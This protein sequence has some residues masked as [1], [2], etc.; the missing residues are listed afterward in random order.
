MDKK[1]TAGIILAAGMSTRFDSLKQL[2]KVGDASIIS[3]IIDSALKS[4][5]ERTV[6]VLGY[7]FDTIMKAM[8]NR[9]D[10]PKIKVVINPRYKEGMSGSLQRGLEKVKD[11]FSSIMIILGD[12]PL[13]ETK[14][15]NLLLN[16][17]RSSDK[18]I[19]VPVYRGKRGLP[20]CISNKF[21]AD[22]MQIEGDIGARHIIENNP[23]NV[24]TVEIDNPDCFFDVDDNRDAVKLL[25]KLKKIKP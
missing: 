16:R 15:I 25:S 12:Q 22:I 7:E 9:L 8:G 24:L 20:V 23:D 2:F 14:T 13:L 19:C 5:L 3:M 11:R 6:V 1:P 21:F 4:D 18:D 10:N 17:F